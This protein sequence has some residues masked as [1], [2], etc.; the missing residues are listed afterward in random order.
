VLGLD[1][2][3]RRDSFFDLGGDSLRAI[4][5]VA[6]TRDAFGVELPVR[7]L[8]E[9]PT[10]EALAGL[11]ESGA[12]SVYASSISDYAT[13]V[14]LAPEI[15]GGG[16][17]APAGG[18][19]FLTGATG[20]LGS[21]LLHEMLQRTDAVVHC[22]V[23]AAGEA[24]GAGRLRKTLE[25]YHLWR[26]GYAGRIVAVPGD[27]DSP[28]FGLSA[29]AFER[30]AGRV[31]AVYH[32]GAQVN[33]V[34]SYSAMKSANVQG[35]HEVLRLAG[36]GPTKPVHHVS[37]VSVF[38]AI[39]Y[40]T[41]QP[42]LMEDEPLDEVRPYLPLDIGYVQSKWVAEQLVWQARRRGIPVRVYRPGLLL[43]HSVTGVTNPDDFISRLILGCIRLGRFPRLREER[44]QLTS[45]DY[46][47][48]AIVRLSLREG[49]DGKAFHVAPPP[50][51][52]IELRD[53]FALVRSA[54]YPLAE[55]PY[56]EWEA[57]LVRSVRADD[58]H[59]LAPLLPLFTERVYRGLTNV[60]IYQH[61]PA[62]DC[63]NTLAGLA[64]SGLAPEEIGAEQVRASLDY[65]VRSGLLHRPVSL[66]APIPVAA[67][68]LVSAY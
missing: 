22:L 16:T 25:K 55:V 56:S 8:F 1:R 12:G 34:K 49:L 27:L 48:E 18:H 45:I 30:L 43:G 64:G 40:F 36:M 26:P 4:E 58:H 13:E 41:R 66:R 54:G 10:V 17:P 53:L 24:E 42:V 60:E 35:T 11:L 20:L 62:Y 5:A 38:G 2:I 32:N 50:E 51:S 65:Y 28:R 39:G 3:G 67:P 21:Y 57:A 29:E 44:I 14:I 61:T 19:L 59:P 15:R 6:R 9:R 31:S 33:F 68:A 47:A 37:T 52:D 7:S 46:A 23:R 63:R